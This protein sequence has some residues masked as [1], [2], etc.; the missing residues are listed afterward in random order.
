MK[1]KKWLGMAACLTN[2]PHICTPINKKVRKVM[3]N[4]MERQR[5][6]LRLR[7]SVMSQAK[8]EAKKGHQSFNGYVESLILQAIASGE[9][10]HKRELVF[11]KLPKDY[12]VSAATESLPLG[13]LPQGTS[14]EEETDRMWEEL[15]R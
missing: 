10:E 12:K 14:F 6:T 7:P 15:A 8:R 3:P 4:A 9:T 1:K 5:A 2:N 13:P 11:P